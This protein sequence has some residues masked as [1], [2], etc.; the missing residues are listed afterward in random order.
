MEVSNI[1]WL[2]LERNGEVYKKRWPFIKKNG[3]LIKALSPSALLEPLVLLVYGEIKFQIAMNT[4][5]QLEKIMSF[6][7]KTKDWIHSLYLL[8]Q[9]PAYAFKKGHTV[10]KKLHMMIKIAQPHK[11]HTIYYKEFENTL[12][13]CETDFDFGD[14]IWEVKFSTIPTNKDKFKY[15]DL[16]FQ[17]QLWIIKY[18][19]DKKVW[20]LHLSSFREYKFLNNIE[21][22]IRVLIKI[23]NNREK[24]S[25]SDKMD[26]V[27]RAINQFEFQ[28]TMINA[29]IKNRKG[30]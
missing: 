3:E 13:A 14:S 19:S 30:V 28:K 4:N 15:L 16:M 6:F 29:V 5:T 10:L 22:L 26:I 25:N 20:L 18:C 8:K 1:K 7:I 21:Q 27:K 24:L 23:Y 11:N 9:L 17:V 2:P 12:L